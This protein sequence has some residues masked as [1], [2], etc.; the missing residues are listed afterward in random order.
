MERPAAYPAAPPTSDAPSMVMPPVPSVAAPPATSDVLLQPASSVLP[1]NSEPSV[2]ARMISPLLV[3]E[4]Y[5]PASTVPALKSATDVFTQDVESSSMIETA[6]VLVPAVAP[7][8]FVIETKKAS[9]A[10][11][12]VSPTTETTTVFTVSPGWN[13]TVPAAAM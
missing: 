8:V 1:L 13:V 9:V 5:A 12:T 4:M 11:A 7:V 10:S 6:T 3:C 2:G